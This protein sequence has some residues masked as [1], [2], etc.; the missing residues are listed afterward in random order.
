MPS[1]RGI[2]IQDQSRVSRIASRIINYVR[3]TNRVIYDVTSKRPAQ[4]SGSSGLAYI[5]LS[6]WPPSTVITAPVI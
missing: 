2:A 1:F 3:R 4:S 5:Q 6:V